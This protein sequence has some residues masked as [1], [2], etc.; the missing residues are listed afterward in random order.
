MEGRHCD[1]V[2]DQIPSLSGNQGVRTESVAADVGPPLQRHP[3]DGVPTWVDRVNSLSVFQ[4]AAPRFRRSRVIA[5]S[6]SA[7]REQQQGEDA[8]NLPTVVIYPYCRS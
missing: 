8:E 6:P 7:A 3:G 4:S 2:T 1:C 5:L